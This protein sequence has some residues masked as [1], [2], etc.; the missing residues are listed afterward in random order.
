M[1]IRLVFILSLIL[2]LH[3]GLAQE[4]KRFQKEV[5]EI[6]AGDS[7]YRNREVIIFT[8]SSTIRMWKSLTDDFREYPV[9]NHGFGGSQMTDL[10]FFDDQLILQYK[11]KKIF[12]YEGDNDIASSKAT[13][14]I[15]SSADSLVKS[16]RNRFP[17]TPL[18][19]ISAK[20]SI[21]RWNLKDK[22]IEYNSALKAF[23]AKQK[24]IFYVDLW[25]PMIDTNGVVYQ[26]IFIEDGLHMNAEGYAIWKKTIAPY[27][28]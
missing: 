22:Y 25:T 26:D 9:V 2:I 1:K 7:S 20:P 18:Y 17:R 15:L 14:Q 3:A 16:I 23:A 8:G 10:L 13:A 6:T 21:S 11:P 27:L 12:I 24:N 5:E 4:S 28:K 19:F